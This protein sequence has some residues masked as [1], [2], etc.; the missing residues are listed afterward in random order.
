M[1][2]LEKIK[3]AMDSTFIGDIQ[4]DEDEIEQMKIDCRKRF[5]TFRLDGYC[6]PY[7]L[8]DIDELIVLIINVSKTWSDE[9]E[10][11]FW[12][13][14]FGEILNNP[15]LSPAIFYDPFESAFE[16]HSKS[17]FRS[18]EGKRMFREYF[19]FHAFA[20]INSRESFIR[21]LWNWY[22]DPTLINYDYQSY[23]PL[24]KEMAYFLNKVFI[25]DIDMDEDVALDGKTYALRSPLK[26]LFTEEIIIGIILL[27]KIFAAFDDIY[28]NGQYD[29]SSFYATC[30]YEVINKIYEENDEV[31]L[32][33]KRDKSKHTISSLNRIQAYYEFDGS[34][35]AYIFI[36]DVRAINERSSKY[37]IEVFN[38]DNL[39]FKSYNY[40]VGVD[41]RRRLKKISIPFDY[42]G[43]WTKEIFH[44]RVKLYL[45]HNEN[46]K[47]LIYDSKKSLYR[48]FILFW[49]NNEIKS[50]LIEPDT[51]YVVHPSNENIKE[52]TTC[53][54]RPVNQYTSIVVAKE[55]DYISSA[56]QQVVFS[57]SLKD[58]HLIVD[59]HNIESIQF[60]CDEVYYPYYDKIKSLKLILDPSSKQENVFIGVDDDNQSYPLNRFAT[61]Y[62]NVYVIDLDD[63]G[64]IDDGCHSIYIFDI[65]KTKLLHTFAY[66]LNR[67]LLFDFSKTHY[68]FSEHKG[69]L[70]IKKKVGKEIK[71]LCSCPLQSGKD[72]FTYP[73]ENGELIFKLPYIKWRIDDSKDYYYGSY[74]KDLWKDNDFIERYSL[75]KIENNS[76]YDV[77]LFVNDKEVITSLGGDYLLGIC[78]FRQNSDENKDIILQIG[79]DK[80]RLL[81][82]YFE[83]QLSDI[84][85]DIEKKTIN[86]L[87]YYIGNINE[88]FFVTIENEDHHYELMT[89]VTSTFD[90]DIAIGEYHISVYLIGLVNKKGENLL[91]D[92]EDYVLGNLH[93]IYFLH[94]HIVLKYFRISKIGKITFNKVY[95]NDIKYLR[96][97]TIG[98]VYSGILMYNKKKAFPVEIYIKDSK[99]LTFYILDGDNL[100][101]ANYDY[102]KNVFVKDEID[103]KNILP[104]SSCYYEK[105]EI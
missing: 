70:I 77:K 44:F 91:L 14:L 40:I 2:L 5:L 103:E 81:T 15:S 55:E 25:G 28:F 45:S 94:S 68:V 89:D 23:D 60:K 16:A 18:Y 67:E 49:R 85:I 38:D 9:K 12:V 52:L 57:K 30:C 41:F 96:E 11:R 34:G 33:H 62:D 72:Y 69:E 54:V 104:C 88:V 75:L 3:K 82:I 4:F 17:I 73:F 76:N 101:P 39:V 36:P 32:R 90:I 99:S 47:E 105:E 53:E 1:E 64:A 6:L 51:Y 7:E 93:K 22:I 74:G 43:K 61:E 37:A 79:E 35:K 97:E 92:I 84:D 58:S 98:V 21:L 56:K 95:I 102:R 71:L 42:F 83:P 66:Y 50:R 59:G 10:N 27:N 65:S 86:L 8:D 31:L 26:Y 63:I 78:L 80:Y 100:L 48:E 87:P 20:P 19:L 46:E 13:K 29:D 24:Y